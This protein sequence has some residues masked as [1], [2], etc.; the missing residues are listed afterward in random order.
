VAGS[1]PEGFSTPELEPLILKLV[2]AAPRPGTV[3]RSFTSSPGR[4]AVSYERR[5]VRLSSVA[6][7]E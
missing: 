3:I 2:V 5:H 4:A 1:R 7:D 6:I